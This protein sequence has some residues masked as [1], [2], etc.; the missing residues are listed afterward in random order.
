MSGPSTYC[1]SRYCSDKIITDGHVVEWMK[2]FMR[3]YKSYILFRLVLCH[4]HPLEK[5]WPASTTDLRNFAPFVLLLLFLSFLPSPPHHS[6]SPIFRRLYLFMCVC[7]CVSLQ[8][9]YDLLL[10]DMLVDTFVPSL[11]KLMCVHHFA[12]IG[13]VRSRDSFKSLVGT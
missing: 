10:S 8:K 3:H 13:V 12:V 6:P 7:V 2:T 11:G 1:F 4:S 5:T 9:I